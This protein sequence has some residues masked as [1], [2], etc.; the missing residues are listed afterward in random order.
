[1][2][3]IVWA[4]DVIAV[5]F[6]KLPGDVKRDEIS[7]Q[8]YLWESLNRPTWARAQESFSLAGNIV[9]LG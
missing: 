6:L 2:A 4:M 9:I 1:V 3:V 7:F 8:T 5:T